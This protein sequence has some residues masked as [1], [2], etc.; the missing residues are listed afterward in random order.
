[1]NGIAVSPQSH[2]LEWFT[3]ASIG[4]HWGTELK[5]AGYDG[6]IVTGQAQGPV[7]LWIEDDRVEIRDASHLW[8]QGIFGI[9]GRTDTIYKTEREAKETVDPEKFESKGRNTPFAGMKLKGKALY[10]IVSGK[11]V[12]RQGKLE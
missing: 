5:Y 8:G 7:Y 10:T 11:V 6:L 12:M 9:V 3:R 4:G 1:M 2:P